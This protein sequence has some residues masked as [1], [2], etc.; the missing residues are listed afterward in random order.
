MGLRTTT[1]G[2]RRTFVWSPRKK[3]FRDRFSL[4]GTRRRS[5][6]A[7]FKG[8]HRGNKAQ[9]I[10]HGGGIAA[11][12]LDGKCVSADRSA[13]SGVHRCF[14]LQ[15]R[16]RAHRLAAALRQVSRCRQVNIRRPT[17]THTHTHT[18]RDASNRPLPLV[19]WGSA[20][21]LLISPLYLPLLRPTPAISSSFTRR[22]F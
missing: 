7:P 9:I 6:C 4:G 13:A 3:N 21:L 14:R 5:G 8:K 18:H 12:R 17:H 20:S 22:E 11:R 16:L 2:R 19:K 15:W 10:A 1:N